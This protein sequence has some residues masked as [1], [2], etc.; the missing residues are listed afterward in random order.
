MRQLTY[1]K[2]TIQIRACKHTLHYPYLLTTQALDVHVTAQC[3]NAELDSTV[4][5]KCV[6][7]I[8]LHT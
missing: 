5:C 3:L 6:F 4:V 1:K 7:C 8:V 2:F